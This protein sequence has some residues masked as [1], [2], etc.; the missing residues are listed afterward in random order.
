MKGKKG[1]SAGEPPF[2]KEAVTAYRKIAAHA[3]KLQDYYE[4]NREK[5]AAY[6]KTYREVNREILVAI[7][8]KAVE[9]LQPFYVAMALGMKT[10]EV[11]PE[12]LE[13]KRN[14]LLIH[15]ALK[16]LKQTINGETS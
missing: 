7:K 9:T 15:R 6:K 2:A 8:K 14:Q 5:F 11:T 1:S 16:Q 3:D 13:L 10:S 12:L 4:A